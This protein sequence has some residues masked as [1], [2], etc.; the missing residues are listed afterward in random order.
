MPDWDVLLNAVIGLLQLTLA[1]LVAPQLVRFGRTFPWLAALVAY[2]ALRGT[3]R[4]HAAFFDNGG[5]AI[6]IATDIV[7]LAVLVLLVVALRRTVA[8]LKGAIDSARLRESEY[9][10]AL[11]DYRTLA[12]HRLANPLTAVLGGIQTLREIP[13]LDRETQ[14]ELLEGIEESA[15]ELERISLDPEAASPEERA[16]NPRPDI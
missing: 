11:T 13:D 15:R 6:E 16:L 4:L 1:V 14:L 12:R 2:F 8:G 9:Q 7:L 3:A 10:R 5:E